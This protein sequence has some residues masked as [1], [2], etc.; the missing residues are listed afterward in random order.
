MK[1]SETILKIA[2]AF[3]KAQQKIESAVKGADNPYFKSKYANLNSVM[4]ACKSF[5]NEFGISV[6]QPITSDEHGEYV[7]TILLH[8]SGEF[9]SS[10][11]KLVLTKN[12]MQASGSAV[13][14]ARRYSLQSLVFI[15]AEDDD[16]NAAVGNKMPI[17]SAAAKAAAS[18]T[19][20]Q[21]ASFKKPEAT[22]ATPTT[23]TA[24]PPAAATVS[25]GKGLDW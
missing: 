4:E 14:Y 19:T 25:E 18:V 11:M 8:E 17:V 23:A 2:P 15:G 22:S 13:S 3:L 1:T 20:K 12:D 6:L 16:G 9:L 5:L 21:V 10:R 7:E 24:A